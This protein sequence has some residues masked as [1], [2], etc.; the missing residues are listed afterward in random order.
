LL[1]V[2]DEFF[3]FVSIV[4]GEFEFAFFGPEDD[5]L[6]FHA[7]DHVEGS[8]GFA[9]QSDFEQVFLDA[10]F[11]G[12]A[13]LSGDFEVAIGWTKSLDALMRSL[14]IVILD[15]EADA[16]PG[17]IEAF[18]LGAGEELLPDRFP[19]AFDLPQGHGMMG[20]GFEVMDAVLF[21][22]G[23][24]AGDAAPVHIFAT[25]VGEHFLGGLILAGGDPEH[26]Q[27]IFG[28]VAAKEVG[29]DEEARVIIHEPDEVGIPASEP[30]GEDVGLPHLVGSSAF[31]E[32]R[33]H[34]VATRLGRRFN[35]ALVVKG[36]ADGLRAGREKEDPP[37]QL[38]DAFDAA[39]GFFLFEFED[40]VADGLGQLGLGPA[41]STVLQPL[42]AMEPV[43]ADPFIDGGGGDAHLLGDEFTGK[44][45]LEVELDRAPSFREGA[46]K[47]FSRSPP[48]GG[49]IVLLLYRFILLHVDT[50]LSLKCQ[51]ISG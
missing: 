9:A 38:G 19:E 36:F 37:Q 44:A 50:S 46:A 39:G 29:A 13:Q 31:E 33:T 4:D 21:H 23:L 51:P 28:H 35:Q 12:F 25:V 18:E 32:A 41:I 2:I 48:R 22:L 30:E 6:P 14:V 42:L 16:F 7:A 24:E 8:L 26:L 40:L 5:G 15:P 49:G 47:I 1:E 11:D 43:K 20:P 34:Q 27:D 17:R 10:G 3:I 45:L